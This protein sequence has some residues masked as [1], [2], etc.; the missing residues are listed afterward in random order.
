MSYKLKVSSIVP[1][2]SLDKLNKEN[3]YYGISI[4]NPFTWGKHTILLLEWISLHF[5]HCK[6]LI[7]DYLYR[8]NE[9]ISFGKDI[10]LAIDKSLL[11]GKLIKQQLLK[12]MQIF[13]EN[14]FTIIHWK[15]LIDCNA[16][17]QKYYDKMKYYFD[18]NN[19]FH[20][21]I[22]DHSKAFI[23]RQLRGGKSLFLK[24]EDA[25]L[26]SNGYLIEELSTISLLIEDGFCISVYPGAQ[27]SILKE[28][29]NGEF[30][31]LDTNLKNGI[32]IDLTVKKK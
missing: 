26:Q 10:D 8:F 11:V 25:I 15:D 16:N 30:S 12:D 5:K 22:E 21:R 1:N 14:M 27:L 3:C 24:E 29:A 13:P 18:N 20:K 28:I 31:E 7:V 19:K 32:Y 6:I 17:Y 2:I 4:N 9:Y 23:E